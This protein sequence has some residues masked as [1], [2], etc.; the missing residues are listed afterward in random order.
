MKAT[1][2]SRFLVLLVL[3]IAQLDLKAQFRPRDFIWRFC[4]TD[5]LEINP[6]IYKIRVPVGCEVIDCCPGCPGPPPIDWKIRVL[7][8]APMIRPTLSFENMPTGGLGNLNMDGD[9]NPGENIYV[10][11]WHHHHSRI[12]T[13]ERSAASCGRDEL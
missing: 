5:L 3:I 9:V 4:W 1:S 12:Q 10:K 2:S 6:E 11:K 8:E 13:R 7:G